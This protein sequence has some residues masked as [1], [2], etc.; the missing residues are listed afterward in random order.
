MFCDASK[1][2]YAAIVYLRTYLTSG[3]VSVQ[4]LA[5]KSRLSPINRPTIPRLELLACTIAARLA[6]PVK[7]ALN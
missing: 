5:A 2:A 4:L 1:I 6:S 7:E 3:Q